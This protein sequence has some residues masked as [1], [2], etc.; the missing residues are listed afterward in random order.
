MT[1]EVSDCNF[2]RLSLSTESLR[3]RKE[4]DRETRE[5]NRNTRTNPGDFAC[6]GLFRCFAIFSY[7]A[8]IGLSPGSWLT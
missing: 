5:K 1:A 7:P 3:F 2:V 6:F 8:A 4:E